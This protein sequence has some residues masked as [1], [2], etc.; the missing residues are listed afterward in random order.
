MDPVEKG[1]EHQNVTKRSVLDLCNQTM[2]IFFVRLSQPF[3]ILRG[4]KE[5]ILHYEEKS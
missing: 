4:K 3:G 2:V 5:K 1:R